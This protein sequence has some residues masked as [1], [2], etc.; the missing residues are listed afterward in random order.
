MTA[1]HENQRLSKHLKA[2]MQDAEEL[3]KVTADGAGEKV[4]NI[5]GRLS[6]ALESSKARMERLQDNAIETAKATDHVI[7]KN[8]YESIGI[9][10]GI[11]LLV[12]VLAGR[13]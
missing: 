8:P 11:G 2:V 7:R 12:G 9:A 4:R 10:L 5:R 13:R 1:R 3:L 6:A